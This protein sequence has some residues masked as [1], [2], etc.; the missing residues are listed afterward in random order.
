M[1]NITE[2]NL[3]NLGFKRQDVSEEESGDEPFY[4]FIYEIDKL[5]LISN[6]NN[7]C[8]NDNYSVEF[9]DYVDAVC[10]TDIKM[11]TDL[12]KILESNKI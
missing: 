2:K 11:L 3:L 9:F 4:Y 5:C 12:I 10:F 8:V 6:S 1:K 7:E